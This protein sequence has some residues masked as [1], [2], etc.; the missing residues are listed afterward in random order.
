MCVGIASTVE[1]DVVPCLSSC[2]AD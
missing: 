2:T 1:F